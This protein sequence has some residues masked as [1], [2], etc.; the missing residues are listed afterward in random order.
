M[1][2]ISSMCISYSFNY[3]LALCFFVCTYVVRL[4]DAGVSCFLQ[5]RYGISLF[6]PLSFFNHLCIW[7]LRK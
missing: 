1:F 7:D 6:L 5:F 3:I 2:N 4:V